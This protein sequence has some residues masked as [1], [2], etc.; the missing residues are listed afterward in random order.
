MIVLRIATTALSLAL[1]LVLLPFGI[2]QGLST[3]L[4]FQLAKGPYYQ[5]VRW[6]R[7]VHGQP[8]WKPLDALLG[9]APP[10]CLCPDCAA[11]RGS[12]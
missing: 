10:A 9:V 1:F 8:A 12:E 7:A 4:F 6:R 11:K 5:T 2:I 3:F